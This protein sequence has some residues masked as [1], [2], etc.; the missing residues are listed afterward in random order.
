MHIEHPS[1]CDPRLC[2][3]D[4][5]TSVEHRDAALS[6]KPT[7]DDT[8]LSV[9]LTRIDCLEFDG[10]LGTPKVILGVQSV[11]G[12]ADSALTAT[13]A[14]MLAAALVCAAERAEHLARV[15]A[16]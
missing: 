12:F 5:A 8:E 1:F 13:D 6:W 4:A 14:R 2:T 10:R 16:R 7:G 3:V 11:L 9:G 15:D